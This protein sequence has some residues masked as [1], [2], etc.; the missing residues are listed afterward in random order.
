[1][2][3]YRLLEDVPG[4]TASLFQRSHAGVETKTGRRLVDYEACD[5]GAP[6]RGPLVCEL[7]RDSPDAHWPTLFCSPALI[8]TRG[9]L[10]DLQALGIDNLE[11]HPVR[12]EGDDLSQ[13]DESYVLLNILGR[14]SCAD[15]ANSDVA[16]IDEGG[17]ADEIHPMRIIDRLVLDPARIGVLDMFLVDEDT[18]CIIVSERVARH[19]QAKGHPDIRFERLAQRSR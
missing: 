12:I 19:L 3:Y 10:D 5:A 7:D 6:F 8:A 18:D 17:D 2:H 15:L 13:P 1:M 9:F 14:V 16:R 11:V 4:D